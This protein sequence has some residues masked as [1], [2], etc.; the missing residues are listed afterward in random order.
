MN[1]RMRTLGAA[2]T[3][4]FALTLAAPAQVEAQ[5][6]ER[7]L[8]VDARGGIAVP[9]GDLADLVD[10]GPSFGLGLAYRVHP[11]VSVRV[12]GDLDLYGGADFDD[13]GAVQSGAPDMKFLHF[14]GG[15]EYDV[16]RRDQG[17]W[18]VTVNGAGGMTVIDSDSFRE[19]PVT[20]PETQEEEIAF[21]ESYFTANGGLKVG[22]AVTPMATVYAGAQWYVS[23]ADQEDTA[24]FRA[25]SPSTVS[26]FEKAQTVPV[27]LGLRVSF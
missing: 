22:Y 18:N 3:L 6:A 8:S 4:V 24:V 13:P 7:P 1:Y 20:N 14:S 21:L 17:H 27:T 25:L 11:R 15:L 16:L 10:A 2:L 9:T 26:A 19:G 12:D 5:V 23:F